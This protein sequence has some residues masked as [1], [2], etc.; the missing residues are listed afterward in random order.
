MATI[1]IKELFLRAYLGFSEHE[2]DKL[3]DVVI[4]L[5]LEYDSSAAEISDSPY[6]ALD[7]KLITKKIVSLVEHGRFNLIEALARK[8]LDVAMD[9]E[10][11]S[12][13]RVE[14]A[15]PHALR[16]AD[17]VSVTLTTSRH[18]K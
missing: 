14:I 18:G 8:V 5:T 4:D 17:S 7:Y 6:D 12:R 10:R 9:D 13:A 2:I 1:H 3:Q 16:F 15:K 11:V